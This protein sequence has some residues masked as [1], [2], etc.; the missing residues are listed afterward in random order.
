LSDMTSYGYVEPYLS[1]IKEAWSRSTMSW[2][3]FKVLGKRIM[4]LIRS[5]V[6]AH[7]FNDHCYMH[8]SNAYMFMAMYLHENWNQY[9]IPRDTADVWE[10]ISYM[11]DRFMDF[12]HHRCF[13]FDFDKHRVSRDTMSRLTWE[14]RADD[15]YAIADNIRRGT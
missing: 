1:E 10:Q 6:G 14:R 4:E 9:Y 12:D 3:D 13:H 15:A 2:D 7:K 8:S 5:S 11:Y